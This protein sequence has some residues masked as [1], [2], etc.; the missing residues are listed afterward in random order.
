MIRERPN[1]KIIESLDLTQK[2][3]FLRL[4]RWNLFSYF[5]CTI[6]IIANRTFLYISDILKCLIKFFVHLCKEI[7]MP[8]GGEGEEGK[9]EKEEEWE[10]G[11]RINSQ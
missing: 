1:K 10:G 6:I 9:R 8:Q 7:D 2:V 11:R 4:W 5:G 3:N